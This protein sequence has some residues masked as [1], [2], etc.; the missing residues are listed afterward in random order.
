MIFPGFAQGITYDLPRIF[1]VRF[2]MKKE[3]LI[4]TAVP[5]KKERVRVSL[6]NITLAPTPKGTD[7]YRR[8]AN[9]LAGASL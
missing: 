9:M 8:G 5:I 4:K 1:W 7:R 3:A 6:K 2:R